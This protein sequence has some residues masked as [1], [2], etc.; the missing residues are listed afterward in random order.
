MIYIFINFRHYINFIIYYYYLSFQ[1]F[2]LASRDCHVIDA[3]VLHMDLYNIM[4][5]QISLLYCFGRSLV[6]FT[7]E[8][9]NQLL[10]LVFM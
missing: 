4:T 5:L 9:A 8:K 2:K 6:K 1:L 7:G 10:S 3:N